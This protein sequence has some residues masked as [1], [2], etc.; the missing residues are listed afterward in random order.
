MGFVI[1]AGIKAPFEQLP[2]GFIVFNIDEVIEA[3]LGKEGDPCYGFLVKLT[4][5]A[6]D[7]VN[8]LTRDERF[9]LGIRESDSRVKNGRAKA[10]PEAKDDETLKLTLGRFK[11]FCE[12]A[13]IQQVEGV[14]SDQLFSALKNRKIMGKVIHKILPARPGQPANDMPFAQVDR[15][16]PAE[17]TG[18]EPHVTQDAPVAAKGTPGQVVPLPTAAPAPAP[19]PAPARAGRAAPTRVGAR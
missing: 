18:I 8:G 9:Y 14:D 2:T 16:L 7:E 12:E 13:G 6:P 15:W 19:A 3:D 1:P 10:D 4:A 11:A 5:V 17:G